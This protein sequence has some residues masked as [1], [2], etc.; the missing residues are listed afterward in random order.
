MF[1]KKIVTEYVNTRW[2]IKS[3]G[4]LNFI[5][6]QIRSLHQRLLCSKFAGKLPCRSVISV[7]L[8]CN[9]I[10]ITLRYGCSLVNL[11]HIFRT[12]FPKNTT[13]GLLLH[14]LF[15]RRVFLSLGHVIKL[16]GFYEKSI[17]YTKKIY[18]KKKL[19]SIILLPLISDNY[20]DS[21]L[22]I[23]SK[24]MVISVSVFL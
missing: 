3:V 9:F 22:S 2:T 8:Q 4:L 1:H 10:E 17:R 7:N 23:V 18:I 14:A 24:C 6:L 11:L 12:A 21:L 19:I 16:E 13:G 5:L 20:H 15:F